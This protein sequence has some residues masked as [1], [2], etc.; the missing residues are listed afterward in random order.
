MTFFFCSR[1][2]DTKKKKVKLFIADNFQFK[3]LYKKKTN[4]DYT[5]FFFP[6]LFISKGHYAIKRLQ[7]MADVKVGELLYK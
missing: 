4:T 6:K 1:H 2:K 3:T 7:S 5:S